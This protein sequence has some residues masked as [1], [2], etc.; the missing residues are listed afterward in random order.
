MSFRQILVCLMIGYLSN[1]L[2]EGVPIT[3]GLWEMSGEMSGSMIPAPHTTSSIDCIDQSELGPDYFKSKFGS[4]CDPS[5]LQVDGNM[6]S[7][8]ISCADSDGGLEVHFKF[9]SK[10]DSF[11]GV[12]TWSMPSGIDEQSLE[13][14]INYS[15]QRIDDCE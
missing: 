3:P 12:G 13:L 1:A 2:A 15:G 11:T 8:T 6:I 4:S 10:G 5:E 9:I 7:W 14:T